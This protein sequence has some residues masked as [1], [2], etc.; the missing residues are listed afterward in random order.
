MK[1]IGGFELGKVLG[2]GAYAPVRLGIH[3]ETHQ[4]A[5]VKMYDRMKEDQLKISIIEREVKI[6]HKLKHPGIVRI[7]KYHIGPKYICLIMEFGG[8]QSLND[9]VAKQP[10][11]RMSEETAKPLV[12]Q[13]IEALA[14]CHKNSVYHR[15]I[16]LDNIL[17]DEDMRIKLIDF[18]FSEVIEKGQKSTSYCGAFA[19]FAPEILQKQPFFPE[20]SDIWAVGVLI[21]RMIAGFFPFQD[22]DASELG[23]KI[24][25]I[26]IFYPPY[27]S[28]SLTNLL[29]AIFK[30]PPTSR[31]TLVD[32]GHCLPRC[33]PRPGWLNLKLLINTP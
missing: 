2:K 11:M 1:E 25:G 29:K 22:E 24:S 32:V 13:V 18:G 28:E 9:L 7:L 14:Y 20:Y 23:K 10:H 8:N 31:V 27:F 5:A 30:M 4:K 6:L 19:F 17:V 33:S 26:K 12:K 3:K 21:Y 16:K 15:D